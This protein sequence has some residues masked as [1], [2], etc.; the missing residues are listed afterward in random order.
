MGGLLRSG[1]WCVFVKLTLVPASQDI[2]PQ[3]NVG[4]RE[5]RPFYQLSTTQPP[6]PQV[7]VQVA[8]G[9]DQ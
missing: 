1:V 8:Q 5:Q 9:M 2:G 6:L 7:R 3:A 4:S